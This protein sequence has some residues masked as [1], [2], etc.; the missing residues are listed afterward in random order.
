LIN[1]DTPMRTKAPPPLRHR[2]L[3]EPLIK[4]RK[5][6]CQAHLAAEVLAGQLQGNK[7]LVIAALNTRVIQNMAAAD[8]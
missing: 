6:I 4:A 5:A 2:R 3:H 1:I 8:L 7:E